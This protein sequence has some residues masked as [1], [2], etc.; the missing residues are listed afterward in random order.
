[1]RPR[2]PLLVALLAA[3][4][5]ARPAGVRAAPPDP[6]DETADA[7]D[8]SRW[9]VRR[10]AERA[11]EAEGAAA[12][13]AATEGDEG[14]ARLAAWSKGVETRLAT[15]GPAAVEALHS[16]L[17]RLE[18]RASDD[19]ARREPRLLRA[20]L[21]RLLVQTV[22]PRGELSAGPADED[23]DARSPLVASGVAVRGL[24]PEARPE[25]LAMIASAADPRLLAGAVNALCGEAGEGPDNDDTL[26]ALAEAWAKD[27]ARVEAVVDYTDA[28]GASSPASALAVALAL[29]GRAAALPHLRA[30]MGV[31]DDG[32]TVQAW[33]ER[34]L[35]LRGL[36]DMTLGAFLVRVEEQRTSAGDEAEAARRALAGDLPWLARLCARRALFLDAGHAG[37]RAVLAQ[38][39]AA[40]KLLATARRD[41]VA[42]GPEAAPEAGA[43]PDDPAAKAV[44]DSL[45]AGRRSMRLVSRI[46][47][48]ES[49]SL[50][51]V[52]AA[53]EDKVFVHGTTRGLVVLADPETGQQLS[54]V[55]TGV[56][57]TPR[58]LAVSNGVVAGVTGRGG[59][60]FWKVEHGAL[61]RAGSAPGPYARVAAGTD[62][63]F[64][65]AGAH[66]SIHR[67]KG[68][69]APEKVEK[70]ASVRGW[71]TDAMAVLSDGAL[72]LRGAAGTDEASVVRIDP[73]TGAEQVLA[74]G[75]RGNVRSAGFGADV[76]VSEGDAFRWLGADGAPKGGGSA[77]DGGRIV[78]LAGDPASGTAYLAL[79]DALV[80]VSAKD[81]T[82]R[83][84]EHVEGSDDPVVGGGLICL[85][86]GSGPSD[87]SG[88]GDARTDRTLYV[89]RAGIDATDPFGTEQR[90]RAV[91]L[92]VA[93]AEAGRLRVMEAILDP[94]SGWLSSGE[95]WA[96][97]NAIREA[98]ARGRRARGEK[99]LGSDGPPAETPA[100]DDEPAPEDDSAMN[101]AARDD[102]Q[103]PMGDP[104]PPK[105]DGR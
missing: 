51:V 43:P 73:T 98:A 27:P 65:F 78:G 5:L 47:L 35:P 40:L 62:G 4:A 17:R 45:R 60:W 24:F 58:S 41:A 88:P 36:G 37:A 82:V 76:L 61:E 12:L 89:L 66:R 13:E 64:W 81:G 10:A 83:W 86:A 103:P 19:E 77:P 38:A 79:A 6:R 25:L 42:G 59:V 50:G 15:A 90:V 46:E 16:V 48:E 99:G 85:A 33:L 53:L 100:M 91:D 87:G 70:V 3:A 57:R 23:A 26:T 94:V 2:L 32:A 39:D 21:E 34:R 11:L 92:A 95:R 74:H 55:T 104:T 56:P 96:A 18:L 105:P 44:D 101:G 29:S 72:L 75:D 67:S 80:A 68:P 9:E 52:A 102:P 49:P 8:A 1:M 30:R 31:L 7:L 93:E 20:R 71:F 14:R 28:D 63:A 97:Q 54:A 22:T 69:G 84:I